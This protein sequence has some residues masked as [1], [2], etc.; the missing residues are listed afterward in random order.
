MTLSFHVL[1]VQASI[2]SPMGLVSTSWSAQSPGICG[3][4]TEVRLSQQTY[5]TARICS[6]C[7]VLQNAVLTLSCYDANG[8]IG[9][10]KFTSVVFAVSLFFYLPL[11]TSLL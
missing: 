11:I 9:N 2:D 1:G 7:R 6:H 10:A 8:K 5:Y 4:V 3:S